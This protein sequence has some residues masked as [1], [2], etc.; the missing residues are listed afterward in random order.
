MKEVYWWTHVTS[1]GVGEEA[2]SNIL[3]RLV[4]AVRSRKS[5]GSIREQAGETPVCGYA[6]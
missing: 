1:Q 2:A 4:P 5:A 6:M 3:A